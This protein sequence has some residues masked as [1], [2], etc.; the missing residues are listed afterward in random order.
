MLITSSLR[1]VVLSASIATLITFTTAA[2]A[3]PAPAPS[4]PPVSHLDPCGLL[5]AKDATKITYH[6]V[7]NCYR[8]IPFNNANAAVTFSTIHTLFNEFYI[9]KDS[10]MVPNLP[11]PFSSP[12]TDIIRRLETIGRTN[13]TSDYQFHDD[14]RRAINSLYDAHASYSGKFQNVKMSTLNN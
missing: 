13:Y 3:P 8:A 2:P 10:A 5:G 14:I 9:F 6:D 1:S 12:P 4:P 11:A 7:A